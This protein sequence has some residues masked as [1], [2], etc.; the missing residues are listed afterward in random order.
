MTA[1]TKSRR[2]REQLVA[3]IRELRTNCIVL[4]ELLNCYG[5]FRFTGG[6]I[7]SE[8]RALLPGLL[9][10][11]AP[12]RRTASP[13]QQQGVIGTWLKRSWIWGRQ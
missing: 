8:R 6:V 4:D 12:L 7:P 5:V 9:I 3:M 1:P 10:C 2:D 11:D 13:R